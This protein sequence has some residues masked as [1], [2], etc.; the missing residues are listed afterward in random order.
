MSLNQLL[1]F[2][3]LCVIQ[4]P[5]AL[6]RLERYHS[7]GSSGQRRSPFIP[8]H[9]PASAHVSNEEGQP[10][11]G[12]DSSTLVFVYAEKEVWAGEAEE[13]GKLQLGEGRIGK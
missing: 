12:R 6:W 3:F 11:R 10:E 13:C 1:I 9:H 4:S 7:P 2:P 5:L 8:E